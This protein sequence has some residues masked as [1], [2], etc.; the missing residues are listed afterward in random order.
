MKS[1]KIYK[2]PTDTFEAVK[3]GWSWPAFFFTW[4]WAYSKG[5]YLLCLGT[6]LIAYVLPFFWAITTGDVAEYNALKFIIIFLVVLGLGANGNELY[7][8]K[9]KRKGF[10]L[11]GE[12]NANNRVDAIEKYYIKNTIE[13]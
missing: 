9:L 2:D 5:L 7:G 3:D 10:R 12:Q 6:I 4:I 11:V 1:F 8:E 13:D